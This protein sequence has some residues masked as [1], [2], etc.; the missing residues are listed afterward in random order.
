MRH[1]FRLSI[2]FVALLLAGVPGRSDDVSK[3]QSS[4]TSPQS[5]FQPVTAHNVQAPAKPNVAELIPRIES[6]DDWSIAKELTVYTPDNLYEYNNGAAPKY[7]AYGFEKLAHIRYKYKD[8]DFLSIAVDVYDM[9]SPLGAYGIYSTGHGRDIEVREGWGTEGYLSGT[10]AVAWKQRFYIDISAD[11]DQPALISMTK[12]LMEDIVASIPKKDLRP[13]ILDLLP[14]RGFIPHSDQYV[15]KDLFGHSFLPGGLLASYKIEDQEALL[16]VTDLKTKKA[17]DEALDRLLGYEKEW[18][19]I[20]SQGEDDFGKEHFW[21]KDPGLG[22]GVAARTGRYIAG[23]W[24]VQSKN[25]AEAI[26]RRLIAELD[27]YGNLT[28]R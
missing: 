23:M 15:A 6:L 22:K 12:K 19:E 9:G 11:E 20:E 10:V 7:I 25:E 17:A 2:I 4:N 28:N 18:G 13:R 26:L 16:F 24:G 27:R 3:Q 21:A 8:D 5:V 14:K 1:W